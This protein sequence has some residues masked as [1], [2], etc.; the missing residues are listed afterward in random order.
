MAVEQ[1]LNEI[2]RLKRANQAGYSVYIRALRDVDH[3]LILLDDVDAFVPVRMA[4]D[5]FQPAAVVETSPSNFQVWLR[6]GMPLH[7]SV[8]GRCAVILAQWYSGDLAAASPH[9]SGRLA[10]FTNQKP[11]Y[12]G[13]RGFPFVLL[14]GYPG[15]CITALRRLIDAAEAD[16]IPGAEWSLKTAEVTSIVDPDPG[17]LDWWLQRKA[18]AS[19]SADA[20]LSRVD[21]HLT[22]LALG[23]GY[24]AVEVM[25]VLT[26]TA[27]RKGSHAGRYAALTVSKAQTFRTRSKT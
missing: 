1:I 12:K 9:Q 11:Q 22:N 17:L 13:S 27:T 2:P 15:R 10:G 6:A 3:D 14:R 19:G 5:G 25:A 26:A 16:P 4:E 24:A 7:H 8:R 23:T 21:W 20:D 18:A